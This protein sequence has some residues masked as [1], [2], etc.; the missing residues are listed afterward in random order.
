MSGLSQCSSPDLLESVCVLK[1]SSSWTL[2]VVV[3]C[4]CHGPLPPHS[5]G[6][7]KRN[8]NPSVWIILIICLPSEMPWKSLLFFSSPFPPS[9]SAILDVWNYRAHASKHTSRVVMNCNGTIHACLTGLPQLVFF[10]FSWVSSLWFL[11]PGLTL[12]SRLIVF[13]VR[14][15]SGGET[16][17]TGLWAK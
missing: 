7:R 1:L 11:C 5:S 13:G 15:R 10:F 4:G 6:K 12:S 9:Y 2:W 3:H 16:K 14:G 8:R 17:R